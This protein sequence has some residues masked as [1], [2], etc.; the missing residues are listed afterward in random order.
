MDTVNEIEDVLAKAAASRYAEPAARLAARAAGSLGKIDHAAYAAIESPFGV[1]TAAVTPRGLVS[2]AFAPPEHAVPRL[3]SR[4]TP[5]IVHAPARLDD[6]R[7]QLDEYFAGERRQFD[8][9]LDWR[10][11][12][13]F[14]R[15]VL[16][17]TARI[18]YGKVRS[19]RDVAARAGN[20]RA[21]RAAG[22]ALHNNPIPIVVP[23]HRVIGSN[24]SLV[25]YGGGLDMKARLLSMEGFT[26]PE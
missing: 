25:G 19:Y 6:V 9:R 2:L 8:V 20:D 7:R 10:L 12:T 14:T 18:P 24:G 13:G 5:R 15:R 3:V 17:A 4:L 21:A 11:V 22:T 26:P 16:G 23:C 1:F